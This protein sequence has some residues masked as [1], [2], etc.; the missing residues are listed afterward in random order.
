MGKVKY[1]NEQ[2]NLRT[3]GLHIKGILNI[4]VRLWKN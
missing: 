3:F 2:P 4:L 1:E